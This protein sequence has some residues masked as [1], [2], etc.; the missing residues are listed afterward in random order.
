MIKNNEVDIFIVEDNNLFR[1]A[2]KA[3]IESTFTELKTNIHLF[4]TGEAC[5]GKFKEIKPQVVI[6]DYNLDSKFPNAVDGIKVLD[7]IKKVNFETNV[8]ML[9]S[10]DNIEIALKS[11]HHGASD[12]V[13]KSETKFRKINYSLLNLF[14]MMTAKGDA[15]KYKNMAL[16]LSLFISLLVGGMIAIQVLDPTLLK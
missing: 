13:V 11:F 9:T 4:E 5:M 14:K 7:W 10:E 6:L 16:V 12:Y 8:I 2:L 3:D 15:K 1:M